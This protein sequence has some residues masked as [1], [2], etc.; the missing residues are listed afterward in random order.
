[1]TYAYLTDGLD[2]EGK[3]KID[4]ALEGGGEAK[5]KQTKSTQAKRERAAFA[6]LK[7]LSG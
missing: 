3:E 5:T 1:V 2:Q 7:K 4:R 6:Q